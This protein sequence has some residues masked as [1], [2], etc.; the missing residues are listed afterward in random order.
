MAERM[1]IGIL[2]G[3]TSGDL[4]GAAL[5]SALRK[6]YPHAEFVGIGGAQMQAEGVRSLFPQDRLAVMGLVEPLK[7]LPELL[8]MRRSLCRHFLA[9]PPAVFIGIDSPD[10]NL[11][12][13]GRLR[14][15]GIPT[16]HYVSP[17]VWAWRQGR[18]KTIARNVDL[19][20]TLLP[21]EAD[22]YRRHDVPVAFVGHHL[23]DHLPL[24]VDQL[25]A[26]RAL[27]L[28]PGGRW[29]ALLPGSRA[30]EVEKMGE[31]F[32][33]TAERCLAEQPDL[34]FVIPAASA[35]RYRQLHEMLNRHAHLPVRLVQGQS[36]R[37]IAAADAVLVASGTATLETMLLKK[38]MVVAYRMAWLSYA[39]LSRLVKAPY[40]SLPNLLAGEEL[41]PELLQ[42]RATP[43]A[44]S[45]A[46][47]GFLQN[48]AAAERVRSAFHQQHVALR[49]NASVRAA[50]AVAAL[51]EQGEGGHE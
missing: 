7:R 20:L 2:A 39:L 51:I 19:M 8:A 3:E 1:C 35:E 34:E 15:A 44:L 4:L 42:D 10:F 47:L 12:L 13:E 17:S 33:R 40:V 16:V 43:E 5:V 46:L 21:F 36:R 49:R 31:L 18:I 29:V 6:R 37:V 50:E 26:R 28:S 11:G 27:D 24:T 25:G 14:R 9:D 30:G 22:F 38:P 32:L 48:P 45:R 41:V 23:A